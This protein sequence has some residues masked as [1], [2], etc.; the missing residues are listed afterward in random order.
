MAICVTHSIMAFA[1]A[2]L[3]SFFKTRVLN[4]KDDKEDIALA[5]YKAALLLRCYD[6]SLEH[7]V[8]PLKVDIETFCNDL[9]G[10]SK[11]AMK[12]YV[13]RK[14]DLQVRTMFELIGSNI[15]KCYNS[16]HRSKETALEM[17]KAVGYCPYI[18]PSR[19]AKDERGVFIE[20]N[21]FTGSIVAI[22]P[23][24]VHLREYAGKKNYLEQNLMP[25]P[26]FFLMKR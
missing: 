20:G 7:K 2:K 15:D 1:F 21:A 22:F 6:H 18:G 4:I 23:G 11:W 9:N 5:L 16:P 14:L 10:T 8:D 26:H 13:K 12:K 24:I 17:S 25:D 19:I 3:T